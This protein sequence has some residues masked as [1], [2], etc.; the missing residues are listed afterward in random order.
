MEAQQSA[1]ALRQN[2]ETATPMHAVR[3][4]ITL[5]N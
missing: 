5:N 2:R 4:S 3:F 1:Q